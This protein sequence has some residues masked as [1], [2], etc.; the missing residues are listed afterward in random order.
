MKKIFLLLMIIFSV[1]KGFS[2]SNFQEAPKKYKKIHFV[3]EQK[4]NFQ[5]R[6]DGV[7]A[8]TL[9]LKFEFPNV[10]YKKVQDPTTPG[11]I[12]G[13]VPYSGFFLE[14]DRKRLI[15]LTYNDSQT[16]E[17][18][19][20]PKK[21]KLIFNITRDN[22]EVKERIKREFNDYSLLKNSYSLVVDFKNGQVT[23]ILPDSNE[24]KISGIEQLDILFIDNSK[25]KGIYKENLK[26]TPESNEVFLNK[27]LNKSITPGILFSNN[28]FGIEK[29]TTMYKT[30][31]L[32]SV[33]YE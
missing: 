29:L 13:L 28:D 30:Y 3:Y 11:R 32:L 33:T 22:I 7:F 12:C 26:K 2:Q 10:N 27:T 9:L 20:I 6:G 1:Q 25:L 31:K 4:S 15:R 24:N 19:Y 18:F 16:I 8:D 17:G 23:K 5:L 14:E 21:Q